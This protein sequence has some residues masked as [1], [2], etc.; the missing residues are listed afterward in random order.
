MFLFKKDPVLYGIEDIFPLK[1]SE[2]IAI[3][4][5][6]K[7]TITVNQTLT[8]T[9]WDDTIDDFTVKV[10]RLEIQNDQYIPNATDT[11]ATLIIED[12]AKFPFAKAMVLHNHRYDQKAM[13]Q[14]YLDTIMRVFILHQKLVLTPTDEKNASI[15]DIAEIC[16][17][18]HWLTTHN[19]QKATEEDHQKIKVLLQILAKKVMA[20]DRICCLYNKKTGQPH[21]FSKII[22]NKDNTY[23]CTNPCILLGT[24]KYKDILTENTKGDRF[25]YRTIQKEDIRNELGKAFWLNGAISAGVFTPDVQMNANWLVPKPDTSALEPKDIPVT[26]PDLVRW[27][28]LIA[29]MSKPSTPNQETIFKVYYRLLFSELMKAKLLIPMKT[30]QPL[31]K[32]EQVLK[33]DTTLN[34]AVMDGKGNRKA[35]LM[36]TDWNRLRETF[37]DSWNAVV[38]PVSGMISV[39]DCAINSTKH[40]EEGIYITEE[41]FKE[42]EESI[43]G[44]HFDA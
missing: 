33:K 7:G 15:A 41:A 37:D 19:K 26:N 14:T 20:A 16:R 29:Q 24:E 25:E 3:V 18:F 28:L 11:R 23:T 44:K 2:D 5:E 13:H 4:G 21:M 10:K 30:D 12:G 31:E 42:M 1:D 17:S 27:M 32:G 6:V 39:M 9:S 36:F 35:V 34:F 43:N 38:Q 22:H 40:P 8:V